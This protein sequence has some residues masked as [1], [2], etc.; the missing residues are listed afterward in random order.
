MLWD[1]GASTGGGAGC[2]AEGMKDREWPRAAQR[3]ALETPGFAG[4][5]RQQFLHRDRRETGRKP[6]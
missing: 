6:M 4:S 2:A 3:D 1:A 5:A